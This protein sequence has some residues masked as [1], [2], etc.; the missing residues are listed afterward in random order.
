[1]M[2]DKIQSRT[3]SYTSTLIEAFKK[4]DEVQCKLLIVFKDNNFSGLVSAGDI[5]RAIIHNISV[6]STVAEIMRTNIF[7]ARLG[8]SL[9]YV[10]KLMFEHRMELCPVVDENSVLNHV[11]FWEDLFNNASPSPKSHFS[12]PVIIMAGGFGTR[13]RPLTNVIPKPLIPIGK[14]TIVENIFERFYQYG[15]ESFFISVNYKAEL[16]KFYLESQNL[17]YDISYFKEEKPMGTA[18][19]LSLLKGKLNSTFFVSNCDILIEQDYSEILD[20]HRANNN[21]ITIVAALKNY[22]IPYGTI[23][24]GKNG[25]LLELREKPNIVYKINSGMYILEPSLLSEIPED[26]FYHITDLIK[27]VKDRGGKIGVFPVSD[28]SWKDIGEWKEYLSNII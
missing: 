21:E 15:C 19:S 22:T 17:P 20:F 5:Q 28:G 10:K 2:N 14:K 11:Y 23:E 24:S 13:L 6:E 27:S 12:I 7:I 9:D 8:D 3:I 18:G 16:I 26:T 25:E 4:M 1:M